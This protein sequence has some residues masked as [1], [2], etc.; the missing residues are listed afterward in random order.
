[1]SLPALARSTSLP[2]IGEP[3]VVPLATVLGGFAGATVA[4]ARKLN[5]ADVTRYTRDGA[6]A[7]TGAGLLAYV[8]ALLMAVL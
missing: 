3:S 2:D 6:F 5:D 4:R 8:I 7:G 1:V